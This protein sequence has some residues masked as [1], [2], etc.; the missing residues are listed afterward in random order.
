VLGATNSWR[1]L[2]KFL[3]HERLGTF[4]NSLVNGIRKW[5]KPALAVVLAVLALQVG[6]S[7][8][9][10]TARVRNFLTRQLELSFGRS[11]E[12]RQYSASLFPAPQLDAY[13]VSVAEDPAFGHEYFLRAD[14][15]S[16]GLRWMGLLRGRFELGTLELNKPSLILTR[17]AEGR[18]NLERWLPAV[19]SAAK[20]SAVSA[21]ARLPVPPTHRLKKIDISDGRVDFKVGDNKLSFAFV[22]VVGSV[23]QMAPDRW[24]LDLEAE[25]W[26]SGVPLQL[27]GTVRVSGDVAGTSTRLQPAHLKA[28]WE[29]SS[30]ADVFRL[31]GGQ[32]FGVRGMFAAEATADSGG[33]SAFGAGVA[34]PGDWAFSIDARATG[35]HRWDLTERSDNP[36]L[37]AH[38][39]GLWNPGLGTTSAREIVVETPRSNLRGTASMKNIADRSFEIRLDSAGIQAADFLDWC[40]AFQP[41]VAEEVV[42]A[43]YFTGTATVRGWPP[44][45][46][47]AA[48]SSSGGRWRLPGFAAP[49]NVRSMRGGTQRERFLVEPFAVTIPPAPVTA[50]AATAA[51]APGAQGGINLS[52]FDDLQQHSGSV[53]IEGQV[54]QAEAV[55]A[56]AAAFGR[57]LE[58]GWELKG[59]VAGDLRWEWSPS[60][61]P[62]W[63]GHTDLTHATLQ[64][65]GLN[66]PVQLENLRIDWRNGRR[67]YTLAKVNAFGAAWTGSV[68]HLAAAPEAPESETAPW[69]FELQADRLDAAELDH[70]IGPRA[71]PTWLERLLPSALGGSSQPPPSSAVLERIRAAGE[72]KADEVAIEKVKLKAF[73]AHA[74]LAG[75]KLKVENA[76]AQWSGGSA[77]GS[78]IAT[79]SSSPTYDV[80]ATFNRV[81]LVQTP[82]LA[83]LAD[84]LAGVAEGRLDLRATGI[85]REALLKSLTGKGELRLSKVELRGWDLAGTMAQ[86]EWKTGI[87][88]WSSGA[89]TFHISD[90]GFD[91]NSLRLASASEEFLLKGS[92]SF[93][94]D[95]DLTAESH[96]TGRA[97]RP[98]TVIRFLTISGP[99][100]EPKVSLEKAAAQQPGD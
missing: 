100:S 62:A 85:G 26:R 17:N 99:L 28:S 6:A 90:G 12:V 9:V 18:W 63:A 89:G 57:N 86:G 25:P 69:S 7:L 2:R 96:V 74:S 15:L 14:R 22:R 83:H 78:L 46:A 87:S 75:L 65:A 20:T 82:W 51:P 48:F 13:A 35:I 70:W 76:Q 68:E 79:L 10:R 58:H 16:A 36:R 27:A 59:R 84:H 56:L 42:A 44:V 49:V 19:D 91:L 94:Q 64:V 88:R 73:H 54:P 98:Q 31:I 53:H 5:W 40:R 32:D 11:V 41:N 45:L 95:A 72:L 71:R 23:E 55:L 61:A 81:S 80:A 38:V 43:Q 77:Q 8:L 67:R 66:Q 1:S 33:V 30:L 37:G 50:S 3:R 39:R 93:S 29:K 4:Q 21:G 24:R 60:E 34:A 97:A 52:L 47:E 92:V